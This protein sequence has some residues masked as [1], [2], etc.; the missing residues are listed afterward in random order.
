MTTSDIYKNTKANAKTQWTVAAPEHFMT[1][2]VVSKDGTTIG[3]YQIG[4]GPGI[5]FVQGAMGTARNFMQLAEAL[6]DTFTVYL[7]DRR[8]RG[9]SDLPYSQDYSIRKDVEDLDALL[10]KTVA[11][12]LFGLSAGAVIALQAALSLSTVQKAAIYEP[13]LFVNGAPT[14]LLMR[15]EKEMAQGKV[16]AALITAMQATQMGPAIFNLM[17]HWLLELLTNKA[18][19]SEDKQA[20]SGEVTMRML[21]PTL[22]YDFQVVTEMSGALESF[23][24]MRPEVLLLGGSQSPAFL[25]ADLDAL[26]KIL[27]HVTRFEFPKVGHSA[28]WNYDKQRNPSGQPEVVALELKRFFA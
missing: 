5:V 19:E 15:Y 12:Y 2:S 7:P 3:Y 25:K 17:P 24:A 1:S 8:G 18:M 21:A 14:A 13:P 16:A 27:P 11:H 22:R 28:A 23:K 26:E 4:H 9:L 20:K 6:A 10:A